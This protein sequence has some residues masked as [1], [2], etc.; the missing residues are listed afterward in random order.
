MVTELDW[1]RREGFAL[2]IQVFKGLETSRY[3]LIRAIPY[4]DEYD[5]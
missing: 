5:S 2:L 1:E 3:S 4:I